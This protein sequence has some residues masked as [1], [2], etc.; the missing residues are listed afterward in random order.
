LEESVDT[1]DGWVTETGNRTSTEP[2]FGQLNIKVFENAKYVPISQQLLEDSGIDLFNYV[3]G[4]LG[5]M[6]GKTESSAFIKGDGNGK[7]TGLLHTPT[8]YASVTADQDK[9]D[10]IAKLIEAFYKLPGAYAS[11]GSWLMKRETMGIIRAAADTTTKGTLWSDGL[12]NGTPATLLGRPVYEAVDMDDFVST[13]DPAVA[14]YPIA[15][16]DY[17][18]AYQIVDRV[19]TQFQRD[20]FTGAD[21]GIVKIRARRRVG[22]K[23]IL[24]EAVILVKAAA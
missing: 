5:K 22:G 11:Q 10:I 7:P 15:F 8:D 13:A 20:D 12:A 18:S 4:Q 6:F 14:T 17:A 21:N 2:E 3:A 16:G 1:S 9:S 23:P 19:Q 24:N